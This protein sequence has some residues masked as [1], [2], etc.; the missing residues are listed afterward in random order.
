MSESFLSSVEL[1]DYGSLDQNDNDVNGKVLKNPSR[2]S[3]SGNPLRKNS[4]LSMPGQSDFSSRTISMSK[5]SSIASPQF[6]ADGGISA[7]GGPIFRQ[8]SLDEKGSNIIAPVGLARSSSVGQIAI[9]GTQFARIPD[10][11]HI[12]ENIKTK[13]NGLSIK[14]GRQRKKSA[15]RAN[16][17]FERKKKRR[18]YFCSIANGLD[19][20]RIEEDIVNMQRSDE[21]GG[22][23]RST[24]FQE[25]LHVWIPKKIS[26]EVMPKRATFGTNATTDYAGYLDSSNPIFQAAQERETKAM[27][28]IQKDKEGKESRRDSFQ[29]ASSITSLDSERGDSKIGLPSPSSVFYIPTGKSSDYTTGEPNSDFP[30]VQSGMDGMLVYEHEPDV[31]MAEQKNAESAMALWVTDSKECFVFAFGS[32]VMWGFSPDEED[33]MLQ[34]LRSFIVKDTQELSEE[35]W[36]ASEDDMAFMLADAAETVFDGEV[37]VKYVTPAPTLDPMAGLTI[38]NDVFIIPLLATTRQRLAL[39]FACAQSSVLGVFEARVQL[40]VENYRYIPETFA[41]SGRVRL[42]ARQLG[43]MIGE[44]FVIRHDVNLHTEILDTPDW[45][46]NQRDVEELYKFCGEYLELANRTDIL[47]TRLDMLKQLLSMLQAQQENAHSVKL[48][49]IVIVL[50]LVSVALELLSIVGKLLGWWA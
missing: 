19:V 43:T 35:E 17:E 10:S 24:M 36:R 16:R 22:M 32:V 41:A 21:V 25:V 18:I 8:K 28:L 11:T 4:P 3:D 38:I 27:P 40:R 1:Q 48:E 6:G 37:E 49:W 42:T 45:F 30:G 47:N 44:V 12:S 14:T 26:T 39:S 46:W 29:Q 23:W 34:Y 2:Y 5:F 33:A 9:E 15:A 7:S 13:T 20:E 31:P 50:I